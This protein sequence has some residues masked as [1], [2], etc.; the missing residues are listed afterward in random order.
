MVHMH[1]CFSSLIQ[2]VCNEKSLYAS[3]CAVSRSFY[4]YTQKG[5]GSCVDSVEVLFFRTDLTNPA[6]GLSDQESL[7]LVMSGHSKWPG[8]C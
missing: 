7:A 5:S 3:G 1:G 2:V 6:Q 4:R 8:A